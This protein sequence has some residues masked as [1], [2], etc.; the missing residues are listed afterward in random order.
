MGFEPH[1]IEQHM[2]ASLEARRHSRAS[3]PPPPPGLPMSVREAIAK[4]ASCGGSPFGMVAL[5][6]LASK[7]RYPTLPV[8]AIQAGQ[9]DFRTLYSKRLRPALCAFID[10]MSLATSPTKDAF[11][12]NPFREPV[13]DAD[14]VTRRRTPDEA[15][16][17]FTVVEFVDA[18]PALATAVFEGYV[19]AL[20]AH[21]EQ[22]QVA[23]PIPSRITV[24]QVV[25]ILEEFLVTSTGGSRLERV[26]VA[27]LRFVAPDAGWD[28]VEGHATNDQ[29]PYDAECFEADVLQALA[30]SKDQPIDLVHLQQLVS[31]MRNAHVHRGFLFTRTRHLPK[32]MSSIDQYVR[33]QHL[34][35][36]RVEVADLLATARAWL[37]LADQSD[38]D[39]PRFLQ[40]LADELDR[41]ASLAERQDFSRILGEL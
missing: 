40:I 16:A 23:Y 17:L 3:G 31:E 1:E 37:A 22:T 10:S 30:E 9:V 4:L 33:S 15:G 27:L 28:R 32:D 8:A 19:D 2:T 25:E 24:A 13:I 12:S 41:W 38:A 18:N 36:E 35:G 14:W 26:T 11:V 39:L 34:L 21:L 20:L 29:R 7:S 5:T 6:L